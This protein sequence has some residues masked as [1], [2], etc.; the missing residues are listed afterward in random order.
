MQLLR[1]HGLV[2]QAFVFRTEIVVFRFDVRPEFQRTEITCDALRKAGK[3]RLHRGNNPGNNTFRRRRRRFECVGRVLIAGDN[4]R[5]NHNRQQQQKHHRNQCNG[6]SPHPPGHLAL[7]LSNLCGA[8]A[9][10]LGLFH[11]A[12]HDV[13]F[14]V[15]LQK[16]FIQETVIQPEVLFGNIFIAPVVHHALQAASFMHRGLGRFGIVLQA[17]FRHAL[18]P[19]CFDAGVLGNPVLICLPSGFLSLKQV[20]STVPALMRLLIPSQEASL[21]IFRHCLPPCCRFYSICIKPCFPMDWS[22]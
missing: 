5:Q 14:A 10:A 1:Q 2:N 3:K 13:S 9:G 19:R 6:R 17:W 22:S 21:R 15:I 16:L 7:F 20:K 18:Q 8:N 12:A 11:P 4:P